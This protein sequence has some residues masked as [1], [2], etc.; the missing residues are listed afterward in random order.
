MP[1]VVQEGSK[2]ERLSAELLLKPIGFLSEGWAH[3]FITESSGWLP[4]KF[5]LLGHC[6]SQLV[7]E[8]LT[9]ARLLAEV[10]SLPAQGYSLLVKGKCIVV[11]GR[12]HAGTFYGGQTLRQLIWRFKKR[13]PRLK[14]IDYPD[15]QWRGAFHSFKVTQENIELACLLKLNVGWLSLAQKRKYHFRPFMFRAHTWFG[16]TGGALVSPEKREKVGGEAVICP[17]SEC[18][19]ELVARLDL[20]MKRVGA[21]G[22][23]M[24]YVFAGGDEAPFGLDERCQKMIDEKGVGWTVAH[25][26]RE[27][28][29]LACKAR[30]KT[31]VCWAD[32]L[33]N[34]EESLV[35]MPKDFVPIYW[36]Y[37]PSL[38]FRRLRCAGKASFAVR[39]CTDDT[40]REELRIPTDPFQRTQ[41]SYSRALCGESRRKGD[42]AYHLGRRT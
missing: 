27:N 23:E 36:M 17:A 11:A 38:L 19:E 5:I 8:F 33:L 28:M 24:P 34:A 22:S 30:G 40:R 26:F 32:A 2:A 35:Y 29:Y 3:L 21:D 10:Q 7:R 13:V 41:H 31:M 39:C 15:L 9:K 20:A 6:E 25:H 18:V 14:I 42:I 4:N 12:G 1:V 16:H 37:Y